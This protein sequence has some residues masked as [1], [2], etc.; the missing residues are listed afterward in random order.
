MALGAILAAAKRL[1]P[2]GVKRPETVKEIAET[3]AAYFACIAE[4]Q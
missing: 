3:K 4:A 2:N 1:Y